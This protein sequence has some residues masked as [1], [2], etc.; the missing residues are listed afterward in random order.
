MYQPLGFSSYISQ[1]SFQVSSISNVFYGP[2]Q[3]YGTT[4]NT[5]PS[6]YNLPP[7]GHSSL[8][9]QMHDM[10]HEDEKED[11]DNNNTNNNDDDVNDNGGDHVPQQQ[12]TIIRGGDRGRRTRGQQTHT[13]PVQQDERP[14]HISRSTRCGTLFHY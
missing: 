4:F 10:D 11:N 2:S 12:H 1:Y 9:T 14:Q 5:P 8:P 6:T 13:N 7:S 3:K